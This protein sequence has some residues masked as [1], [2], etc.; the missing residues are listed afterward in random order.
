MDSLEVLG[1]VD[2]IFLVEATIT[3]PKSLLWERVK[4]PPKFG[5]LR[6]EGAMTLLWMTSWVERKVL[7]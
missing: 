3:Q 5:F 7:R 4:N 1:L 2:V 6:D